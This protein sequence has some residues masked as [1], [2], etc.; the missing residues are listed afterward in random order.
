VKAG[1]ARRIEALWYKPAG[2]DVVFMVLLAPFTLLYFCI[3]SLRRLAY[4]AGIFS[5]VEPGLPVVVVGN[6]TTG[7]TGKTPIVIW[8]ARQLQA[9]GF[10]PGIVSRGYGGERAHDQQSVD[11]TSLPA[12]VGDEPYLMYRATGFPVQVGSDRAKAVKRLLA[13][14]DVDVVVSDDGLQHYGMARCV[15]IVVLDTQRGVGN[16]WLLPAGP[17]RE[18]KQRLAT[19]D[20]I[21]WNGLDNSAHRDIAG[22]AF[23]LVPGPVVNLKTS[24]HRSLQS[25][26]GQQVSALA[27]IGNPQRFYDLLTRFKLK[28]VPVASADHGRV[29]LAGVLGAGMPVFMTEKDAVKY[30]D[31][32]DANCWY[33]PV[34]AA[35]EL[36]DEQQLM[37]RICGK[38]KAG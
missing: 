11:A 6:I 37:Q 5:T 2:A 34:R 19:V 10:Q 29:N 27:G 35:F 24:E 18:G 12:E 30:S 3:T 26:S 14:G 21:L 23:E 1:F 7:G 17:L 20:A 8:L 9:H 15:E 16:G 32:A 36:A 38:L 13:R 4:R 33:V 28:P 31:T 25:F 22:I